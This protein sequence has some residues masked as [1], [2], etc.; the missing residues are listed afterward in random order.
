MT[1]KPPPRPPTRKQ[2]ERNKSR[3]QLQSHSATTP[4]G[5]RP[6]SEYSLSDMTTVTMSSSSAVKL[7]KHNKYHTTPTRRHQLA[8][9]FRT[10]SPSPAGHYDGDSS[11]F[12]YDHDEYDLD[13]SER[14]DESHLV[15]EVHTPTTTPTTPPRSHAA[16]NMDLELTPE[17]GQFHQFSRYL[18]QVSTHP[19]YSSSHT[20]THYQ[21]FANDV[22][23]LY[24]LTDEQLACRFEFERE[25]GYGQWGSVWMCRLL[26]TS[27]MR[28]NDPSARLGRAAAMNGGV[29]ARGRVAIKLAHREGSPVSDLQEPNTQQLTDPSLQLNAF[30]PS[31]AK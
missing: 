30:T 26:E 8:N 23:G 7:A 17:E 16:P 3:R 10:E 25:V 6:A 4:Y 20:E 11:A 2:L 24:N 21:K 12:M 15:V 5:T 13:H 27:M 14:A 22:S 1:A 18:G 9:A 19:H 29:G 28:R 31:G